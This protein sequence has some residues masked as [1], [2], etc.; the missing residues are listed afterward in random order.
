MTYVTNLTTTGQYSQILFLSPYFLWN[1][2]FLENL[3]IV[4]E[5]K[6]SRNSKFLPNYLHFTHIMQ[7][8][9][10]HP[11]IIYKSNYYIFQNLGNFQYFLLTYKLAILVTNSD[12][13]QSHT[14]YFPYTT[15]F[16]FHRLLSVKFNKCIQK[17]H[18]QRTTMEFVPIKGWNE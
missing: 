14:L 18:I 3:Y 6:Y 1:I 17:K 10:F 15:E 7:W 11:F 4:L 5:K 16:T 12:F 2:N 13:D 8:Q 9:K